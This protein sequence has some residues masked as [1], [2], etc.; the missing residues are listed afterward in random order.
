[1]NKF[2][3]IKKLFFFKMAACH[4]IIQTVIAAKKLLTTYRYSR[5]T[6]LKHSLH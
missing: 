1:M 3:R 5:S 2:K 6:D 4:F